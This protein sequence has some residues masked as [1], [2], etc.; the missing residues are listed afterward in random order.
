VS[1]APS[2]LRRA[3]RIGRQLAAGRRWEEWKFYQTPSAAATRLDSDG[4]PDETPADVLIHVGYCELH[5]LDEAERSTESGIRDPASHRLYLVLDAG[6]SPE[7]PV[8]A[9]MF[10]VRSRDDSRWRVLRAEPCET[11]VELMLA[12]ELRGGVVT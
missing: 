11:H 5:T 4:F 12:L 9:G 7:G 8:E 3:T 6:A 1:G 2:T 10:G